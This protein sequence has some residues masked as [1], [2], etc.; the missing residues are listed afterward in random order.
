MSSL[1]PADRLIIFLGAVCNAD[2]I[3][4]NAIKAN[5]NMLKEL[6]ASDIQ[7]RHLLAALEWLC[8]TRFPTLSRVIM[9]ALM[10]LY[11]EE[12]V[13]EDIFL[14]WAGDTIRN[15]YT[16]DVSMIEYDAI[17]NVRSDAAPFIKWLQ[18]AEEEGEEDDEDEEGDDE[19]DDE[20]DA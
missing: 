20:E 4:T 7:Q 14:A 16:A 1:R 18:E 12:I 3:V 17:E 6:A 2:F 11:D 9:K 5:K 19:E 8:G 15:E 13:E 10:Q